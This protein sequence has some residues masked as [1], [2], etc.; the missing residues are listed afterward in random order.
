MTGEPKG[1]NWWHTLPG[2]L[3]AV[4]G[5]I[6][7]VTGLILAFSN[8]GF[9]KGGTDGVMTAQ[10]GEAPS[11]V[12]PSMEISSKGMTP[13]TASADIANRDAEVRAVDNPMPLAT[14][15][16]YKLTLETDEESYFS[17]AAPA[18]ELKIVL[19]MQMRPKKRGHISS[20]LSLLDAD[21][22][23]VDDNIILLSQFKTAFRETK[24]IGVKP[25]SVV[26][27]KLLNGG[28]LADLWLTVLPEPANR[29]VPFYGEVT[30]APFAPGQAISGALDREEHVYFTAPF[31]RG[32][33]KAI[34]DFATVD[35][36][37][38]HIGGNLALLDAD[39]GNHRQIVTLNQ[40]APSHRTTGTF[41]VSRDQVLIV[42]LENGGSPANYSLR[43]QPVT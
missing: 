9:F 40:Y 3:T 16:T 37:Q 26:G 5:V 29:L 11:I 20:K 36:K 1:A 22:A 33:Y 41:A 13:A 31:A 18:R 6:T 14:G 25:G 12:P 4:A 43:I 19:D 35:K 10:A 42:R 8:I 2:V 38:G 28:K 7:A 21:G 17:F 23:V 15:T 24:S 34:L 27:L 30:P 39:G 32:D